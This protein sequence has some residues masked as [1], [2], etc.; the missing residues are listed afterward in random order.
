MSLLTRDQIETALQELPGWRFE[1]DALVYA[2]ARRRSMIDKQYEGLVFGRLD[3]GTEQSTA[4]ERHLATRT[5]HGE[6][7]AAGFGSGLGGDRD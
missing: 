5:G 1:R 7:T 4:A 3:L 2:A 6:Q